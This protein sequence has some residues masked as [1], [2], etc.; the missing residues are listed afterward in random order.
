MFL[1]NLFSS[2][3][4]FS[5]YEFGHWTKEISGH[6]PMVSRQSMNEVSAVLMVSSL[7]Q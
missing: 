7:H 2:G 3:A 6:A 5:L 1:A 4:R